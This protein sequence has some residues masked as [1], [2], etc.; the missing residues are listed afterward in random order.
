[1]FC[2][3]LDEWDGVVGGRLKWDRISLF[4]SWAPKSL[5]TVTAAMKLTDTCSLE[6][7]L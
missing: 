3:D 2:G 6:R 5:K 7:E 4:F 1:M